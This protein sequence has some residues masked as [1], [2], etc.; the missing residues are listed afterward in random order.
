MIKQHFPAASELVYGCMGLGGSW[1]NNPITDADRR[2]AQEAVETALA[3]GINM[4]DHA[5]I[6]TLGKAEAIF[7][8]ILAA[9]PGLRE[10]MIL[11]S[12]CAIRFADDSGPKRYDFSAQ[13][14]NR[15]VDESLKRLNIEQLDILMLH[16]PDPLIELDEVAETI[17]ALIAH[18]KIK[19]IGVSNMNGF[20]MQYLQ[21]ALN[22]PIVV[23][24]LE[25]SLAARHFVEDGITFNTS[26][27]TQ[28][29]FASGTLEYCLSNQV[30]LQAWGALAQGRYTGGPT[31]GP[32]DAATAAM[33]SDLA[34]QY[35][36]AAETIILAWLRRHPARI[37]P[38]IGTTNPQRIKACA[39]AS[40]CTLSREDWYAL[41]ETARGNEVP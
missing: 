13:W 7:G 1:D 40:A 20:Q 19:H 25:L 10:K 34:Q 12:K 33:V 4:F 16:R 28:S 21:S 18:G 32:F 35:E 2:T 5:D 30:Q 38:I 39:D 29:G 14:I 23:N 37:Q 15:R 24:Q 26:E 22:S 8:E 6:Y 3:S 11:Q 17:G 41:F 9:Q 36:V 27:N 31:Q